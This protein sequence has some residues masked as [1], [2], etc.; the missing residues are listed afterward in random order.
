MTLHKP[1]PHIAEMPEQL[2]VAIPTCCMSLT[3]QYVPVGSGA[4]LLRCTGVR[5][6]LKLT[7]TMCQQSSDSVSVLANFI[8]AIVSDTHHCATSEAAELRWV[9]VI[10]ILSK[11]ATTAK[12]FECGNKCR[13][14]L[15]LCTRH[16]NFNKA[17]E[18]L[19]VFLF[20]DLLVVCL[21]A[22]SHGDLYAV[23]G[24][25]CGDG[26]T[27]KQIVTGRQACRQAGRLMCARSDLQCCEGRL[28][29]FENSQELEAAVT[30]HLQLPWTG[31]PL[32]VKHSFPLFC[33]RQ[34]GCPQCVKA[35]TM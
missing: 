15:G 19:T 22:C 2:H 12:M 14:C 35:L 29:G 25:A 20:L 17:N 11:L 8:D 33:Q 27:V 4:L 34:K 16:K 26:E 7:T 28:E 9:F 32:L 21:S 18:P 23:L 24:S 10:C 5:T 31:L 3:I 1:R 6:R 13:H 30:L